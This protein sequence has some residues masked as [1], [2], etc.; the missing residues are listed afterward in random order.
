[1]PPIPNAQLTHAGLFVNDM[2][3]MVAFYTGLLGMQVSDSGFLVGKHLT[4]LTRSIHEHHQLV[5]VAGRTAP[6][7]TRLLSQ[8]SFRVDG[9]DELRHFHAEAPRL[10]ASDMQKRSHGNSWSIYFR[11]PET[12]IVEMYCA[13]PWQV[14]QPWRADLDFGMTN[15]AIEQQT[16][17]LI[18][19]DGVMEPIDAWQQQMA[20]RLV[21]V[22]N[23]D[24]S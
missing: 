16:L 21:A 24:A 10:G 14:H 9:L 18:M 19:A 12:N 3:R 8:L 2:D 17:D 11:D 6:P 20:T 23:G 15:E 4:F 13:T 1:M 7:D 5:L 22:T